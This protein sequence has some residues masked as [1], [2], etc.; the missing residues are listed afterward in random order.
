MPTLM[1]LFV[2]LSMT[3]LIQSLRFLD[4]MINRG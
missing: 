2:M 3:W 4:F 1:A